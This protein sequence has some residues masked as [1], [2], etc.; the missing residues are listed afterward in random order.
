[1]LIKKVDLLMPQYRAQFLGHFAFYC[2]NKSKSID[3][4]MSILIAFSGPVKQKYFCL[5][6]YANDPLVMSLAGNEIIRIFNFK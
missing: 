2:I 1:V 3:G 6:M 4:D 5:G